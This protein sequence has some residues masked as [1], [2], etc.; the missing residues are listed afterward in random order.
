MIR[1][2]KPDH[3]TVATVALRI[4]RVDSDRIGVVGIPIP[5]AVS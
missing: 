4:L 1:V 5:L 3:L 2:T